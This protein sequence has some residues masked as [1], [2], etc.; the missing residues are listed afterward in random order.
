[1]ELHSYSHVKLT[2]VSNLNELI[3]RFIP[4]P[5]ERNIA[6]PTPQFWLCGIQNITSWAM[7]AQIPDIYDFKIIEKCYVAKYVLICMAA[8]E[9]EY[10]PPPPDPRVGATYAGPCI[11]SNCPWSD[12]I[13]GSGSGS[14]CVL[15]CAAAPSRHH[16]CSHHQRALPSD[17]FPC[18]QS[19][20]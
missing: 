10:R 13:E 14:S 2:F 5:P 3:N 16:S 8:I 20:W 17:T 15:S 4:E 6:L 19:A 7:C 9:N 11:G 12:S 18:F 1:M